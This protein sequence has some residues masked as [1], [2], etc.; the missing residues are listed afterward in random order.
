MKIFVDMDGV[1]CNWMYP[2][3]SLTYGDMEATRQYFDWPVGK[4]NDLVK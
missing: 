3:L 1:C 2:A 4:T